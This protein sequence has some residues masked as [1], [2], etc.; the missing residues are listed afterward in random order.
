MIHISI[1][2]PV[3]N[4]ID[5]TKKCLKNLVN[6]LDQSI[7]EDVV[8]SIILIDDGSSDGT[9]KWVSENYPHVKILNGDGG[10]WWSGSINKGMQYAFDSQNADAVLWWNNDILAGE[11][12]FKN[13]FQNLLSTELH[14]VMGSKVYQASDK[15]IVWGMG[16]YFNSKN[17]KKGMHAFNVPD[18]DTLNKPLNVQ[19]LPGMGTVITREVYKRT[20][21]LNSNDFPQYHGDS[22]YTFRAHLAGYKV[23]VIPD[24]KI[25]NNTE[26]S[27][28]P[29]GYSF[30]VFRQSFSSI[31]SKYNIKKNLLFYKQYA[32]SP[33]A[34]TFLLKEYYRYIGGFIKWNVL[35]TFGVKKR[36]N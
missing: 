23:K 29:H 15:M 21:L 16:G 12:Y 4:G 17:G 9:G 1:L 31:K 28:L 6:Q 22:D 11:D 18:S 30:R 35:S 25:Y 19:W 32:T 3:F 33:W 36:N 7:S 34:Y 24:L 5:F 20:G 8:T 2:I 13:L 10:L 14:T 27:G 26:N